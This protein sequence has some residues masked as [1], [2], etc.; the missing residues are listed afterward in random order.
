MTSDYFSAEHSVIGSILI[1]PI[2]VL[3]IVQGILKPED[4]QMDI[5]REVYKAILDMNR[6]G[7]TID[8]VTIFKRLESTL[9][10]I[11]DFLMS[12][13]DATPTA[14]NAEIYANQVK[15]DSMLRAIQE[16]AISVQEQAREAG[17]YREVLGYA[18]DTFSKLQESATGNALVD[19]QEAMMEF[20]NYR[21][22][23]EENPD[24]MFAKTGFEN[25]DN[26]LGGGLVNAGLYIIAARPGV[27]KTTLALNIADNMVERGNP[28]LFISLEMSVKQI[29]AKRIASR[30]GVPYKTLLMRSMNQGEYDKMALATRKMAYL[31]LK[32]NRRPGATVRQIESMAR[33]VKGLRC[34]VVD[35]LGLIRADRRA[36]SRYE[37]ITDISG[38]LKQMAIRLGVPVLC[39]AQLNRET[40]RE[41]DSMPKMYQLRDSGAIE[42]DS[43]GIML[44]HRAQSDENAPYWEGTECECI[45]SKNR[46]GRTGIAKFSFYGAMSKLVPIRDGRTYD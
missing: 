22:A 14:V 30:C 24:S 16:A 18:T 8:P 5:C 42:Q 45:L 6:E 3:P 36:K 15:S 46:H 9:G 23:F 19:S 4:F 40:E 41:K 21:D 7:V 33:S 2:P 17:D 12:C 38:N 43:D 11:K 1:D 39:L 31:P 44:L 32:V 29:T 10:D 35:Y 27:G 37:E 26:L 13:M 20:I 34:I 25:L 28:V